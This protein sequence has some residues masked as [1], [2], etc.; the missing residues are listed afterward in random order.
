MESPL[1]PSRPPKCAVEPSIRLRAPSPQEGPGSPPLLLTGS[2]SPSPS[3]RHR[4]PEALWPRRLGC[5]ASGLSPGPPPTALLIAVTFKKDDPEPQNADF[6]VKPAELELSTRCCLHASR[7]PPRLQRPL[8]T[9][10]RRLALTFPHCRHRRRPHRARPKPRAD[11]PLSLEE[12]TE[13][14]TVLT[15]AEGHGHSSQVRSHVPAWAEGRAGRTHLNC[16]AVK[17]QSVPGARP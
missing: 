6:K 15:A 12:W 17:V 11:V 4:T 9:P 3:A 7:D 14:S 16:P 13:H 5:W 2:H 8:P 1:R 10:A